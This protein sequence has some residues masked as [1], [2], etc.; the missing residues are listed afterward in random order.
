MT[1][2]GT[3]S[4]TVPVPT[5]ACSATTEGNPEEAQ[6]LSLIR[7]ILDEGEVRG[8]R[9][10]TGTIALFAPPTLRFSLKDNRFP[11]LTTKK[12]FLRGVAEELFWFL[13]G[14][15]DA[16]TLQAKNVKIWDGNASREF[17]DKR[18]LGHYRTGDLGPVYGWQWRHFGGTYTTCDAS[19]EGV[20]VDQLRQVIET[21]IH[22]PHDRR[23]IL[24]AWNPAGMP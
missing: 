13:R 17:L 22:R 14:E 1:V 15:T 2:V 10:G 24:S 7:R 19:Y 16:G 3:A 21:I 6:Y 23:I 4:A 5:K 12:T 9:T 8:D 11:L 18:G 20:G